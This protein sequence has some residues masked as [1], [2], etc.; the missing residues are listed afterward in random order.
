MSLKKLIPIILI[1]GIILATPMQAQACPDHDRSSL[2]IDTVNVND[3]DGDGVKDD[4]EVLGALTLVS[5]QP[6]T[7]ICIT[8]RY[9]LTY[10]PDGSYDGPYNY[11]RNW[12]F[13]KTYTGMSASHD[14]ADNSFVYNIDA[15]PYPG[16]Y[17]LR[18]ATVYQG[19]HVVSE[20]FMFDPPGGG[21]GPIGR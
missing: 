13:T 1:L 10:V 18:A 2:S 14:G 15:L 20:S 4:A 16:W 3:Y 7:D 19:Q 8:V 11:G 17:K 9:F 21:P 5:G 12:V 6:Q